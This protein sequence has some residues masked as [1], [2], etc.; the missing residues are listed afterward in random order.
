MLRIEKKQFRTSELAL[1]SFK[2]WL[3]ILDKRKDYY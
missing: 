1:V 2:K 3:S